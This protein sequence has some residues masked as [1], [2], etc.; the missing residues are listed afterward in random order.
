MA[1]PETKF[2][3]WWL[4]CWEGWHEHYEPRRGSGVGMPDV[5][6]LMELP[7]RDHTS[8]VPIEFKVGEIC[9]DTRRLLVSG[10]E[11]AQPSWHYRFNAA[12]GFSLVMVGVPAIGDPRHRW[13]PYVI[14][15]SVREPLL[16]WR[17]GFLPDRYELW[18]TWS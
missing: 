6:V 18:D 2:K 15:P 8:L 17:D 4:S 10:F 12:G 3:R 7:D 16:D 5:Q 11:P 14:H 9:P 1:N 13:W